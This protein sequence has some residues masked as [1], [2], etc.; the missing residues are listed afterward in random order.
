[1]AKDEKKKAKRKKPDISPPD[2]FDPEDI[3]EMGDDIDLSRIDSMI[4]DIDDLPVY[5]KVLDFGEQGSGKTTLIGTF[6][7]PIVLD[8]NEEGTK[9]IRGL[10][11]KRVKIRSWNDFMT[12]YWYLKTRPHPFLTV[13]VDT[14]SNLADIAMSEVLALDEHNGL[15]IK[16]HWGMMTG[17]LRNGLIL[18]RNLP[19]H[20]IFTAQMKRLDEED[21]DDEDTKLIIPSLSPAVLKSIGAAVD[22]IGYSHVKEVEK[23]VNGKYKSLFEYRMRI[24]P[25]STILTKVRT[26]KGVKY[27]A[28]LRDPTFDKLFEIV[29]KKKEE[30]SN[31]KKGK[32]KGKK[33][34]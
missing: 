33:R 13:G 21:I 7:K 3:E 8:C 22:V 18:M 15:P 17:L 5:L 2:D 9:S 11:H 24:G 27:P 26:E 31:G 25:H 12:V 1:M 34:N 20:V 10:G 28:V 4:E 29:M 19:M 6:P 32:Q 14:T 30:E 23:E 16:K